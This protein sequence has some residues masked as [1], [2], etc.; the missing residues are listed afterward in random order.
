[1]FWAVN[2]KT[3]EKINALHLLDNPKYQFPQE[4]HWLADWDEIENADDIRKKYDEIKVN[5]R[6]GS[7]K[8]S[9]LGKKYFCH[10]HFYIPNATKLGINI[11]S[12]SKEHKL[13]KNWIYNKLK[14]NDLLF[15]YSS[16]NKPFK[17]INPIN[18]NELPID[19]TK[20]SIETNIKNIKCRRA[21]IIC[22]F[23]FKHPLFGNGIQIEI[24]FS[25]QRNNTK[26][27]RTYDAAYSG[28]SIVWIEEQDIEYIQEGFM[29]IRKDALKIDSFAGI[30]DYSNKQ[31]IKKLRFTIQEEQRKVDR[32]LLNNLID[33]D[34]ALRRRE[35]DIENKLKMFENKLKIIY[36]EE[37]SKYDD[38]V[39]EY[40]LKLSD[41]SE[42]KNLMEVTREDIKQFMKEKKV[43]CPKC[44]G[45][46]E[47]REGIG[48]SGKPYKMYKCLLCENIKW[49][50]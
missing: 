20:I 8:I 25:K 23:I 14:N 47:Y 49:L 5:Y 32:F 45:I 41:V 34:E 2:K 36:K 22:P 44:N 3:N 39:E 31:H 4:E 13:A 27:Q 40:S 35:K 46:V 48:K 1:M 11:I 50:N 42:V 26:N 43:T 12:E 7:E 30:L 28:Y 16:V 6:D 18:I 17:Y 19:K 37:E 38:M 15:F 9:I 24:Q 29:E 21:D 33:Y 10:P